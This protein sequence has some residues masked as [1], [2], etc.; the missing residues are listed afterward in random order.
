MASKQLESLAEV[1]RMNRIQKLLF[2]TYR[3]DYRWFHN[4]VLPKIRTASTVDTEILVIASINDTSND[5]ISKWGDQYVIKNWFSWEKR[6]RVIYL[7]SR[8]IYHSKF[9][10]IQNRDQIRLGMGSSNLTMSGW[11]RNFEI[12][13]WNKEEHVSNVIDILQKLSSDKLLDKDEVNEWLKGFNF[14][15]TNKKSTQKWL[16]RGEKHDIF[17][18]SLRK[19]KLKLNN[20]KVVR[21]LSPYFDSSSIILL[22]KLLHIMGIQPGKVELWIDS[23]GSHT[24]GH[25]AEN[26]I[27]LC[28]KIGISKLYFPV[29]KGSPPFNV[30]DEKP[31]HAKMIEVV[32]E[33]GSGVR[34][35][36]SAN[37]TGAAWHGTNLES[38]ALEEF[39]RGNDFL[40]L[41]PHAFDKETNIMPLSDFKKR[42]EE[43]SDEGKYDDDL[44]PNGVTP[45]IYWAIYTETEKTISAHYDNGATELRDYFIE[46]RY[47]SQRDENP[48]NDDIQRLLEISEEFVMK[49]NWIEEGSEEGILRIKN[50]EAMITPEWIRLK[51]LFKDGTSI[52]SPII[53]D[54]PDFSKRDPNTG[55][56]REIGSVIDLF[57]HGRPIVSP[58]G[59]THIEHDE[60]DDDEMD[61]TEDQDLALVELGSISES[62]EYN[63]LPES[64]KVIKRIKLSSEGYLD[65]DKLKKDLNY[66]VRKTKS[67][68][69]RVLA[70]ALIEVIADET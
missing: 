53:L 70:K 46:A 29:L 21:I 57:G 59:P 69:Q 12:W 25:H 41:L 26:L 52:T 48:I 17:E 61:N 65:K 49:D 45:L 34:I 36:G 33:D 32:A 37:F 6:F 55:I 58:V 13:D 51:L 10:I 42:R 66:I 38:V 4:F 40:S 1:W 23:T 16:S 7:P 8:P 22:E 44:Q 63:H 9:I 14:E 64:I 24:N 35:I 3:F 50:T 56:P 60:D 15:K 28:E 11:E 18:D 62:P 47:N 5:D 20:I 31:L 43:Q 67:S 27:V 19:I 54:S 30:R 39:S 2:F 68:K